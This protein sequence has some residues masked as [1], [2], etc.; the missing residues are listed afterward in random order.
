M[1]KETRN[2]LGDSLRCYLL[3]ADVLEVMSLYSYPDHTTTGFGQRCQRERMSVLRVLSEGMIV[4]VCIYL[5]ICICRFPRD[6]RDRNCN[7]CSVMIH[8]A[9]WESPFSFS[10][11]LFFHL[12]HDHVGKEISGHLVLFITGDQWQHLFTIFEN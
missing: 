10:G 12:H 9:P 3:G 11:A 5:C 2:V 6:P 4:S 1:S 8:Y 7:C